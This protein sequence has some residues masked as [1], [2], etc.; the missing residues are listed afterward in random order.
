M[1]HCFH[2]G[3]PI[4]QGFTAPVLEVES[5]EREF[6]CHG[7]LAVCRAI[8]DAGLVDY[9]HHR[10]TTASSAS[11]SVIPEFLERVELYDRPDIQQGFVTQQQEYHEAS[12]LLE[13]IRCPA[14]LWLNE[15]HLR[16]LPGVIDVHIDDVSQRARVRWQPGAIQLSEIL[17]AIADIG[18][19][20]HPYDASRGEQLQKLRKRRST[21]KLIFAGA[22][23]MLVM[24]F[25]LATYFM[26]GP[27]ESGV[28]PLWITI[29]RWTSLLLVTMIMSYSGQEFFIGAW[30]DARNR[31]LGMDVPIVL[32]LS[33][34]YTGSIYTTISGIGE[35]YF[36]SIAMF[37]FFLLL[38]RRYELGGKLMAAD[39]VDRLARVMPGMAQRFNENGTRE[40]VAVEDLVPGDLIR[41]LPGETAPVDGTVADGSS[42]FDESL[43]T[44]ESSP[45]LKRAGNDIVAGSVN[46]EQAV[47]IKVTKPVQSSALSEIRQLVE[48]GLERRPYYALLA[49]RVASVFVAV[50]LVIAA[51]TAWFWL[52]TEPA[53]WLPAT[54]A[55]LIVTCP[56]A[57]ALATP[58]AL[59]VSAGRMIQLG[60]IPLRMEALDVL[61]K[62]DY[63][64]FDKTGTLTA[65]KPGLVEVILLSDMGKDDVIRS[66]AAI[67]ADSE[68]PLARVLRDVD[69]KG[70]LVAESISNKPGAGI[71]ASINGRIW[72]YGKPEFAA[73]ETLLSS[74]IKLQVDAYRAKGQ[75]VSLLSD[76]DEAKAIFVFEDAIRPTAAKLVQGLHEMGIKQLSVL[77][78]DAQDSVVKVAKKLGIN[79]CH[80]D[81]SPEQKLAWI[82]TRQKEGH[83]VA[84]FGDG[85][86]DTPALAA[87]DASIS[88][89]DATDLANIS[90][91]FLI[92]GKDAD[93]ILEVVNL[94]RSTRRNIM[95]NFSWAAAYNF[96]AVPFAALGMIPPWGAAIGMSFSS[97]FVVS[98]ALRLRSRCSEAAPAI[99]NSDR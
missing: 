6:C 63:F 42:S 74:D 81:V 79:D 29:G 57:L 75:T 11:Q 17:I 54:I 96:I 33:A 71:S 16:S 89:S 30:N 56:C 83:R 28:L 94:A 82:S 9:Y 45:V 55:V 90:S 32:G 72:R 35:V 36:D 86:N 26:G 20:A 14:C 51:A 88:F 24:N 60:V 1:S 52:Q 70:K 50:I 47:V 85:I 99:A 34:A 91:D 40:Q 38:A 59:T 44:G 3:L 58:V 66:A 64:V 8:I 87:A 65:G 95:Q 43:L 10:S 4:Q 61:A 84:M 21:E 46:G 62:V 73:N 67:S 37:I 76:S 27:D 49:E 92:L 69:C 22:I 80:G 5:T 13:N 12:L 78:G 23:G 41:L 97:L 18:Y 31:R 2:C 68:H 7:C 98:N 39:H 19:V 93:V 48:Q 25:S 77:S 53:N 15:K